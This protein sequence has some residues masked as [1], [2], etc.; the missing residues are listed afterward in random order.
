ML[1]TGCP[2]VRAATLGIIDEGTVTVGATS[3]LV[4]E[5]NE[6]EPGIREL[7]CTSVLRPFRHGDELLSV[8]AHV[9]SGHAGAAVYRSLEEARSMLKVV[10][11]RSAA[12]TT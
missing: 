9:I 6:V 5:A 10:P 1:T 11:L 12:R 8:Y 4:V 7:R 3:F 2:V